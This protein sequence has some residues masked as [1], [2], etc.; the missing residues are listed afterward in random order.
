MYE[1]QQL[2]NQGVIIHTLCVGSGADT[3]PMQCIAAASGGQCIIVPGGTSH[4]AMQE[5]LEDAF[6]EIAGKVPPPEL[7]NDE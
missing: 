5:A 7:T 1:A 2:I 6:N 3:M 4:A